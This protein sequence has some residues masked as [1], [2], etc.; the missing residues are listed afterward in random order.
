VDIYAEAFNQ[1]SASRE[2][3]EFL[4]TMETYKNTLSTNV[5][6]ILSTDSDFLKYIKQSTP[7]KQPR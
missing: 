7:A 1:S 6:L 4:K 3:Y 5:T 2:F